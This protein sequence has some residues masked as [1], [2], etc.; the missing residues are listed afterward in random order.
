MTT[1]TPTLAGTVAADGKEVRG[2]VLDAPVA[3]VMLV[4]RTIAIDDW[5]VVTKLPTIA[6][7]QF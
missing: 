7:N 6:C 3:V 2:W 5:L 1:S 4:P